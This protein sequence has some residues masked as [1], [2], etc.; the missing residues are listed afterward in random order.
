MQVEVTTMEIIWLVIA[1]ALVWVD[2]HCL[3]SKVLVA[4]AINASALTAIIA[5]IRYIV[6]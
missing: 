1:A 2:R 6:F 4:V 5:A 3:S